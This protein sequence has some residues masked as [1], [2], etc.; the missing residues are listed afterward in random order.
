MHYL[1]MICRLHGK[2][3][4]IQEKHIIMLYKKYIVKLQMYNFVLCKNC[5]YVELIRITTHK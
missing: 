4:G 3:T 1:D 2:T 5:V